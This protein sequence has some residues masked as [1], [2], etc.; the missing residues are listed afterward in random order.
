MFANESG[1]IPTREPF[2]EMQA[3]LRCAVKSVCVVE[4]LRIVTVPRSPVSAATVTDYYV[5][6]PASV[7]CVTGAV[8]L[9]LH[10]VDGW[11]EYF[12]HLWTE[13][14]AQFKVPASFD[15]A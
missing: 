9:W 6:P 12:I 5:P 14:L 7:C 4:D 2:S 1:N 15:K 8:M 11:S 10:A 3:P 13:S